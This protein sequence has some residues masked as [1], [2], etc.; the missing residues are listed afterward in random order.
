MLAK[1]EVL[2]HIF[3]DTKMLVEQ[4]KTK[5]KNNTIMRSTFGFSKTTQKI[6]L[7]RGTGNRK[8]ET[9]NGKRG[10]RN[11]ERRTEKEER[12]TGNDERGAGNG[13]RGTENEERGTRR[14]ERGK[15]SENGEREQVMG[16]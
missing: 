11:G 13:E 15:G 10:T 16:K 3:H 1:H 2:Q 4:N 8:R 7:N 5:Q 9:R 14:G 6:L 12:G